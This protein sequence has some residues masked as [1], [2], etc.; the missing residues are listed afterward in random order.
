VGALLDM[1]IFVV[2]LLVVLVVIG[3]VAKFLHGLGLAVLGRAQPA[4][5]APATPVGR[6]LGLTLSR[7]LAPLEQIVVVASTLIVFLGI[8][9]LADRWRLWDDGL[10]D[11][12]ATVVAAE[13]RCA[14]RGET[15]KV[16]TGLPICPQP[17]PSDLRPYRTV[18]L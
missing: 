13:T 14:P 5:V 2:P 8:F 9:L 6:F 12:T 3:S 1:A 4:E 18:D 10:V 16:F 11:V 15:P 7:L 17:I